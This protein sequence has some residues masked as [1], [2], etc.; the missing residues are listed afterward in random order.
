MHGWIGAGSFRETESRILERCRDEEFVSRIASELVRRHNTLR[1][2]P[3]LSSNQ[4]YAA[5]SGP[6][7]SSWIIAAVRT[8]SPCSI[9]DWS[10]W[11]GDHRG[12]WYNPHDQFIDHAVWESARVIR[13]DDGVDAI[14]QPVFCYSEAPQGFR[15]P[16]RRGWNA[17]LADRT[18]VVGWDP[19]GVC[20]R[21]DP[22]EAVHV[23]FPFVP[24]I[25]GDDRH[26]VL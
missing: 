22:H 11:T 17:T 7:Q 14:V 9:E 15:T 13:T 25:P 1:P 19:K 12:T 16:Q 20:D 26:C 21:A 6:L 10:R 18:H 3:G 4:E 5:G 23:G 8:A 24:P 2:R